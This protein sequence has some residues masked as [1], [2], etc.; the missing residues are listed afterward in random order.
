MNVTEKSYQSIK[1][2]SKLSLFYSAQGCVT[3]LKKMQDIAMD[4]NNKNEI[5]SN[6]LML[7][8]IRDRIKVLMQTGQVAL[9]YASAKAHK[10]NDLL[11]FIEEDMQNRGIDYIH[12]FDEQIRE[13]TSKAK[14]LLPCR[15]VFTQNDEYNTANWPHTMLVQSNIEDR[16]NQE[17]PEEQNMDDLLM[18]VRENKQTEDLLKFDDE[19]EP[20]KGDIDDLDVDA[21]LGGD[22]W[23]DEI[24]LDDDILGDMGTDQDN[25]D[26]DLADLD[27]EL[28]EEEQEVFVPP[29]K[30]NDPMN[31]IVSNSMIPAH[32]I[33]IG[34]F[35]QAIELLKKQIG[36][37][38]PRPLRNIF[39]FLHS[40]SKIHIPTLPK[41]PAIRSVLRSQ[42]GSVP[43]SII[44]HEFLKKIY[45]EGFTETTKGNFK[46][47]LVSFQKCIQYAALSTAASGDEEKEIRK[48]IS[49]CVE[50][51]LAMKV[52]L[53]RRD[54]N[55]TSSE[56]DNL[57]LA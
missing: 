29:S 55:L 46:D 38:N 31:Q 2:F 14:A 30:S 49:S 28:N 6:S 7:G 48:L 45:K 42:D 10:L 35:K 8:T 43:V 12:D 54:K 33:A 18:D 40:N 17:V 11:P 53:K 44:N 3:K 37:A 27:R 41:A 51:I 52:E 22:K 50:Y 26:P 19:D 9:A 13:R 34:D 4:L 1:A 25:G 39:A 56:I 36:L 21:D 23:G 20:K 16:M 5:F 32:H 47:A 15:P 24:D 57:E